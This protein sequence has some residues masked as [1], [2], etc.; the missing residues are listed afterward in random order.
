VVARNVQAVP[1]EQ[2]M[3]VIF[4]VWGLV[5]FLVLLPSMDYR[6]WREALALAVFWP[7]FAV[8]LSVRGAI[9]VSKEIWE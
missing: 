1:E 6:P 8:M 5:A 7:V 4:G 3:S 2:E 9:D